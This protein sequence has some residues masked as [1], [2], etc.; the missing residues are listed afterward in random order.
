MIEDD[1]DSIALEAMNNLGKNYIL[2]YSYT[3][4]LL[5]ITN[6]TLL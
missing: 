1:S 3:S 2:A 4:F 5:S 6:H